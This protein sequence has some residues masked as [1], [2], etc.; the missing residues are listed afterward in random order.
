MTDGDG[1]T[2]L[3]LMGGCF[4]GLEHSLSAVEGAVTAPGYAGGHRTGTEPDGTPCR[5]CP[6]YYNLKDTGDAEA[7]RVTVRTANGLR[8]VLETFGSHSARDPSPASS[9][10]YVRGIGCADDATRDRVESMVRGLGMG[11]VVR[12]DGGFVEAEAR[13]HGHWLGLYGPPEE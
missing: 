1:D 10:R 2:T 12:L 4:W 3:V 9:S 8:K 7:V 6:T 13:H 5:L 11:H